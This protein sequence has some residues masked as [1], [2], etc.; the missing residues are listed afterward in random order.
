ML[1]SILIA[2]AISIDSLSVGIAYGVKK[3]KVPFPSL[4]I[5]D[6]LSVTLL[7]LGFFAGNILLK[8]VPEIWTQVIGGGILFIMGSYL[9]IQGWINYK[10]PSENIVGPTPIAVISIES[11]GIAINI[12]RDPSRVDLDISGI[13]DTKEAVLL[14]IALAIDSLAVG[15]AVAVPSIYLIIFTLLLVAIINI[16]FILIGITIGKN[17]IANKF[18]EK[19][20][21]LPG[22]ILISL[23]LFRLI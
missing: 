8:L 14:G 1:E 20:A 11:L 5:L 9:L 13:I 18:K 21:F 22:F 17:L 16:V 10:Y 15:V 23:G 2:I 3:I 19:T 12:L 4:I 7:G 6:I